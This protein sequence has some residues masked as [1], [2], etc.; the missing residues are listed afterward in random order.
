ML[1][2]WMLYTM[3]VVLGLI[4]LN[5]LADMYRGLVG[6][7]FTTDTLAG[8]LGPVLTTVL[9]LLVVASLTTLD[10]TGWIVLTG[11]YVA[12]VGVIL[13]NLSL[14]KNKLF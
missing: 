3:W 13:K 2:G 5:W 10:S 4:G 9:P 1:T 14:L 6:K 12:G 7:T 8:V 11:Y